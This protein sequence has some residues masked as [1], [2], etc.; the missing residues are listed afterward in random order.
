MRKVFDEMWYIVEYFIV[1]IFY[2]LILCYLG[3]IQ[4]KNNIYTSCV[5]NTEP[6]IETNFFINWTRLPT[7]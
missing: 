6:Y 1:N 3:K 7:L 2:F 4:D 5:Y